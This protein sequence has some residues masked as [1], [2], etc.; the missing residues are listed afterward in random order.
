MMDTPAVSGFTRR[1]HDHRHR[2]NM[3]L[4][5]DT[6]KCVAGLPGGRLGW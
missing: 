3:R 4:M 5:G 2:P 6:P 1:V